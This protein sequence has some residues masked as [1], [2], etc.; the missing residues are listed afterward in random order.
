MAQSSARRSRSNT[1]NRPALS[2]DDMSTIR[3]AVF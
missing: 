3:R 1:V 2:G